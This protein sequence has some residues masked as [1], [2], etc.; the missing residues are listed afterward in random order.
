MQ[1]IT[2]IAI[3]ILSAASV[4]QLPAKEA[5]SHEHSKKVVEQNPPREAL[6]QK[7]ISESLT[8]D[9]AMDYALGHSPILSVEKL[10]LEDVTIQVKES[11]LEHIPDIYLSGEL[12]RNLIIP[13]TPV[14]AHA[15][16]PSS[17]ES[18]I[19]YLQFNT[20]WNSSAGVNLK[21]DLF[22][23]EKLHRVAQQKQQ[24]RIQEYEAQISIDDFKER[25]ALAYA[26]CV[27]AEEQKLLLLKDTVYYAG[28]LNNANQLY[29]KER[30]TL[31]VKNDANR[32]YNES[33]ANFL[34]AEKIAGERK[35][36]LLYLM[37]MEVTLENIASLNLKEDITAL[38]KNIEENSSYTPAL[39]NLEEL[40][41]QEVV[42]LAILRLKTASWKY[43]PTLTING[44]YG[45]S[46]YNNEP[47]FFNN[48]YWRGNS[49]IGVSLKVPVTQS[50]T[51]SSEVSRLRLQKQI[52]AENLRDI[53]NNREKEL[54]NELSLLQVR[55][56]SYRLSR[57]NWEMSQQNSKAVQL[58]FDKG[59]IQQTDLLSEQLKI[60]QSRQN[61]LQ[62]AYNLFS[63][64]ITVKNR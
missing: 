12:R 18:E 16:N 40:R 54:L 46:Y 15:F 3:F 62:A 6:S 1:K 4:A 63:S 9:R 20:K 14:P 48:K 13:A 44:Y 26:E 30:I 64:I 29:M 24:L 53:R 52:E 35:A 11:R 45:S 59:Y 19:M 33:I 27:I 43:A 41:Q 47:S 25:L 31:A 50:L 23:P 28:L 38:L 55:K 34:E 57:E 2:L 10:K 32:I 36:E 51:T 61:Y 22:N 42:N 7:P 17:P 60:Q 49:Y 56:E 39:N 37:G 8:L 58:Q 5:V 21:Y